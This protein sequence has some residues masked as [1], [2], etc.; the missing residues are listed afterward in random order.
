M[1]TQF[2]NSLKSK[3]LK[4]PKSKSI[5]DPTTATRQEI[6]KFFQNASEKDR[7]EMVKAF[8]KFYQTTRNGRHIPEGVFDFFQH[9]DIADFF[10]K[11]GVHLC[12]LSSEFLTEN[13]CTKLYTSYSEFNSGRH[14]YIKTDLIEKYVR[15]GRVCRDEILNVYFAERAFDLYG[16]D[17]KQK[18]I[19]SSHASYLSDNGKLFLTQ[20]ARRTKVYTTFPTNFYSYGHAPKNW[21]IPEG[22]TFGVEIEMLFDSL[23]HKLEFSTW[24]GKK[25]PGWVCEYDGSLEDNG[26]AG[27]CG[28]ELISPPLLRDDISSKVSAICEKAIELGGKGFQ[29][30]VYYG[31][32]VTAQVPKSVRGGPSRQLM[33]SRYIAMFNVPAL[34]EFW[35]LVARRKGESFETY[36]PFKD[37]DLETCLNSEKGDGG[38]H[39]HRRAVFVR[40]NTLL[41]TRIFRSNLA[42][43]QVR[44]NIEICDLVMKFCGRPDFSLT[45]F[46]PFWDFLHANMS[47][48]LRACLYRKKFAPIKALNSV[49][50]DSEINEEPDAELYR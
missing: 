28:L 22:D 47:K 1:E 43:N 9:T 40:N 3:I 41:E 17:F 45:N 16:D 8:V 33:A 44:A 25:F 21:E 27:N 14:R 31:M 12:A 5:M 24:V 35:Q 7:K 4:I 6:A 36:S 26:G 29:A 46:K 49:V 32:H 50:I 42:A 20:A 37:I 11:N 2:L 15:D 34:R 39:A 38:N 10:Q 13:Q 30:G 18:K 23:E 48:D 19:A